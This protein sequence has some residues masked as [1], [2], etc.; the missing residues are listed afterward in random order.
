MGIRGHQGRSQEPGSRHS[1]SYLRKVESSLTALGV[2]PGSA[3]NS[4]PWMSWESG[5]DKEQGTIIQLLQPQ[6]PGRE[7]GGGSDDW[8]LSTRPLGLSGCE[9]V[10]G[11]L[12]HG[13]VSN[14]FGKV[15]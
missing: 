6:V 14:T 9:T 8:L 13:M 7:Q 15:T 1:A 10:K 5:R 3:H 4:C 11:L 2:R 12:S